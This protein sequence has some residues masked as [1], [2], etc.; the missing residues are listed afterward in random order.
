[1]EIVRKPR[2]S[3]WRK[4]CTPVTPPIEVYPKQVIEVEFEGVPPS[5]NKL[6]KYWRGR[7]VLDPDARKY[8][9]SVALQ[10]K[11]YINEHGF[12][13]F[14]GPVK[15]TVLIQ[16]PNFLY[17]NG[18]IKRVDADNYLKAFLDSIQGVLQM[19][20]EQIFELTVRKCPSLNSVTY[21][22]LEPYDIPV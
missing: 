14:T 11:V 8:K 9:E 6:Y 20:D 4:I 18:K 7:V 15:A 3:I 13:K 16:S 19:G 2:D 5:A 12:K 10:L 1:M 17:K 22:R 21:L